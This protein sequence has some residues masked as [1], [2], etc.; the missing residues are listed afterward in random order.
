MSIGRFWV[1]LREQL[2]TPKPAAS[3]LLGRKLNSGLDCCSEELD[4]PGN[5][6]VRTDC[7]FLDDSAL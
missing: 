1:D 2:L 6:V 4:V 5:S 3:R 7:V